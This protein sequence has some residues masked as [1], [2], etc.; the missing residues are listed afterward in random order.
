MGN[1]GQWKPRASYSEYQRCRRR[2]QVAPQTASG[3]ASSAAA[4]LTPSVAD[5]K[6]FFL[7]SHL[8]EG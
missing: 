1:S 8:R 3:D 6:T 5:Q 7:G 2:T 4:S